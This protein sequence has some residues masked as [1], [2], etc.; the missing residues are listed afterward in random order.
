MNHLESRSTHDR[1]QRSTI[2]LKGLWDLLTKLNYSLGGYCWDE[3]RTRPRSPQ[4]GNDNLKLELTMSKYRLG[5]TG[6]FTRSTLPKVS[7]R[8][9]LDK[10]HIKVGAC[11]RGLIKG[12]S[13]VAPSDRGP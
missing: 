11:T 1:G 13:S 12:K 2:L 5:M 8:G 10:D 6:I 7:L 9:A 4:R 3:G